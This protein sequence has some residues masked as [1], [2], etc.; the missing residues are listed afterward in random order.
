MKE[1]AVEGQKLP[2]TYLAHHELDSFDN[3]TTI[4]VVII[5]IRD[6][7]SQFT[8]LLQ[9]MT[10]LHIVVV[11]IIPRDCFSQFTLLL[12]NMTPLHL[13]AE[14]DALHVAAVL[15]S[16]GAE[17]DAINQAVSFLHTSV[18]HISLWSLHMHRRMSCCALL[19]E[20]SAGIVHVLVLFLMLVMIG[21][22]VTYLW[23]NFC[24]GWMTCGACCNTKYDMKCTCFID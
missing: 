14:G 6:C 16:H 13:A 3:S 4:I 15:L 10:P 17:M 22:C 21:S 8:L 1:A 12:Q 24:L 19:S 5:I 23:L 11:I 7:F 2:R 18:M 20:Q 9:N